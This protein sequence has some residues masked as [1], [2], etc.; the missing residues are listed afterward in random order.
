MRALI[1]Y[2]QKRTA[3][4][5]ASP[6]SFERTMG[7]TSSTDSDVACVV[8]QSS[9]T[10]S[11][12]RFPAMGRTGECKVGFAKSVTF[13]CYSTTSTEHFCFLFW[14]IIPRISLCALIPLEFPSLFPSFLPEMEIETGMSSMHSENWSS[15]CLSSAQDVRGYVTTVV[16]TVAH[17]CGLAQYINSDYD[18]LL[19]VRQS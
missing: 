13:G 7:V 12:S 14:A 9:A 8:S 10:S 3:R 17:I 11:S 5:R 1:P 19:V 6:T 18:A 4:R 16:V 2:S 15:V